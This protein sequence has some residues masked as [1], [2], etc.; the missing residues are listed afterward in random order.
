MRHAVNRSRPWSRLVTNAGILVV[1][2]FAAVLEAGGDALIHNG[3]YSRSPMTRSGINVSVGVLHKLRG[4]AC[5]RC[6][7][8]R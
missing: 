1:L 8:S 3:R 4:R 2:L 6:G 7:R 5:R